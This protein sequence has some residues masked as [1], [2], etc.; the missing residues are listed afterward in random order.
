MNLPA[1]LLLA[2]ATVLVPGLGLVLLGAYLLR[3]ANLIDGIML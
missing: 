2:L 3:N 1:I